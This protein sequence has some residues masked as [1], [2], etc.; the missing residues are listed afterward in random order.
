MLGALS[1]DVRSQ[2]IIVLMR[3]LRVSLILGTRIHDF[4]KYLENLAIKM[5]NDFSTKQTNAGIPLKE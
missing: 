1:S 5:D 4:L 3:H 2:L